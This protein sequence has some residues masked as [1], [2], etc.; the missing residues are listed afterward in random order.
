VINRDTEE[1]YIV[2]LGNGTIRVWDTEGDEKTVTFPDGTDY[3]NCTSPRKELSAL[4]VADYTFISNN[5]VTVE[6]DD[7]LSPAQNFF[8]QTFLKTLSYATQ[9]TI[10][11]D[12]EY[13]A[14]YT[15]LT[16]NAAAN[17]N[18][19]L[20]YDR[21]NGN[22]YS[23]LID[24]PI[25]LFK[26]PAVWYFIPVEFLQ[27]NL[28]DPLRPETV[29][30]TDGQ[31]GTFDR[32]ALYEESDDLINMVALDQNA[33]TVEQH[34]PVIHIERNDGGEFD[35]D[36]Y[37]SEGS[38]SFI[39][40]RPQ[41]PN[42]TD[43]PVIGKNGTVVEIVGEL[44]STGQNTYFLKFITNNGEEGLNE[45]YW[46]ETVA[47]GIQ[48]RLDAST[49][50]HVL[51]RQPDGSFEFRQADW[52][53]RLVGDES[54]SPWPSF[55]G[56]KINDMYF[57][58]RRLC[59]L[60]DD[61]VIMSRA[62]AF[63]SF[64]AQTVTTVL[65]DGPID[66]SS[67]SKT[68]SVLRHAIPYNGRILLFSDQKQFEIRVDTL[69][70][71]VPPAIKEVTAFESAI[72][73]APVSS[74]KTIF[75][76]SEQ[77]AWS[78]IMEY[79]SLDN[80][81]V[82]MDANNVTE[83]V[84]K[85]IPAGIH[86]MSV[87]EI[88]NM[89]IAC[90]EDNSNEVY[91]YKYHWRNT[92]IIQA[93]WS[94]WALGDNASIYSVDFIK[95]EAYAIVEYPRGVYLMKLQVGENSDTG[96][97]PLD[98]RLDRR[99]TESEGIS[100]NYDADDNLTTIYVPYR[101]HSDKVCVV[102]RRGDLSGTRRYGTRARIVSTATIPYGEQIKVSGDW[103]TEQFF[104]GVEYEHSYTFSEQVVRISSGGG[105]SAA[106]AAGRLQYKK[107][108]VF[109]KDT[110]GFDVDVDILGYDTITHTF[111]A[112]TLG[113]TK[114]IIGDPKVTDGKFSFPVKSRSD[115]VFI[116]LKNSSFYPSTFMAAEWEGMFTRNSSKVGI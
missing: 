101:F 16:T 80:T 35:I 41:M 82:N 91:V 40:I 6:K 48:T 52:G 95:D 42:F 36:T 21:I 93:S 10:K 56:K 83:H 47:P 112:P 27:K 81:D 11:I 114:N 24:D 44:E 32:P 60:A 39:T 75:F 18:Y 46:K 9:Y 111:R 4:T 8:G 59:I 38:T 106:I 45:G 109:Y 71:S 34:G 76:A 113:V 103:S 58:R 90:T 1:R 87:S 28:E 31:G 97:E 92:E 99:L 5:T 66:V 33:F 51:V 26:N 98:T 25:D 115:R 86:K 89:L 65:D 77:G 69:L 85:Y 53:E 107:W 43:L 15:S 84:P 108:H 3:L 17:N 20:S 62:G 23:Y 72:G 88:G 30:D 61:N 102:S 105:G 100:A 70:A 2:S 67:S 54:S 49:M 104:V 13:R 29:E 12:G 110:Y 74:G 78:S 22:L 63:F 96:I 94:T 68:V 55:V 64:F 116:T 50:P 19:D 57:D 79:Y 14:E 37:D 7:Y 73:A